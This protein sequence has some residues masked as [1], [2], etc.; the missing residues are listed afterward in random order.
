MKALVAVK[1]VLDYNVKPRIKPDGSAMDLSNLKMAMNP[2]CEIAVEAA[3]QL[4]EQGIVD[5]IIVVTLGDKKSEEQLRT[6]LALGCDQ[7]IR[8]EAESPSP[9][10]VAKTLAK[11]AAQHQ[12]D[13]AL[14]GK[15][16]ID[17]DNNQT[18][19]MLAARLDWSQGTFASAIHIEGQRINTVREVDGGL[20]TLSLSLP[21]VITTDL[22]LNEP[23]FA[24]LPDIMKAKRKPLA[25]HTLDELGISPA[26]SITVEGIE[27]P[28]QRQGGRKVADV[29]ELISCLKDEARVIS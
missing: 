11:L 29:D 22:R 6:A 25:V 16:A 18:G 12:V 20:E 23:R 4:K 10:T 1:R 17:D 13:I 19:Q 9:L 5:E 15:Q 28:P 26:Q 24:K 14:L 7:A 27:A 21:A 8:V 3:V 2:F